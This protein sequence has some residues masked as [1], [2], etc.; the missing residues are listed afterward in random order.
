MEERLVEVPGGQIAVQ[1]YGGSGRDVLLVHGVGFCGLQWRGFAETV[2]DRCRPFTM[3]LPG[4][5]HST[6]PMR[7]VDDQWRHLAAAARGAGLERPV[8]VAHD[9]SVWAATVAAIQEPAAFSAVVLV[10]GT[11]ARLVQSLSLVDDPGFAQMLAQRFRLG[12]TGVGEQAAEVFIQEMVAAA[13]ADWMLTELGS[14]YYDEVA[15]SIVAGPDGTWMNT[16]TVPTVLTAHR[17][18]PASEFFPDPALY[19]RLTLPT[20]VVALEHGFDSNLDLTPAP[21]EGMA[22]VRLRRLNTGQFPQY[23]GVSE[24]AEVVGEALQ[25]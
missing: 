1:S 18:D 24:L 16:P 2:N 4:H 14:G 20:W 11:M 22:N 9:T 8:L 7:T 25:V 12:E 23:S 3:D 5:A 13:Q 19:R 15:H 17:F 21:F 6:V 10:G